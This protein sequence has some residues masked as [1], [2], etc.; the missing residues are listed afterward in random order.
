MQISR[1]LSTKIKFLALIAVSLGTASAHAMHVEVNHTVRISTDTKEMLHK[2]GKGSWHVGQL[3]S[4][5]VIANQLR[6]INYQELSYFK[7]TLLGASSLVATYTL[8]ESGIRGLQDMR[9]KKKTTPEKIKSTH[10]KIKH[11][12]KEIV[13]EW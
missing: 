1:I 7:A 10:K 9:T 12:I 11:A 2:I 4:I 3:A 5:A 13:R 8:A 6:Q